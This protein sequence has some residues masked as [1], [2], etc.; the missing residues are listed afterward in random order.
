MLIDEL[1]TQFPDYLG[2]EYFRLYF[3][4]VLHKDGSNMVRGYS[5]P[6]DNFGIMF[7]N[8][9]PE[10]IAHECLHG[11]G[12]PHTFFYGSEEKYGKNTITYKAQTTKNIMDYSGM[13][14][15]PLEILNGKKSTYIPKEEYYLYYWQWKNVNRNIQ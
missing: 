3:M 4:D 10:T 13:K 9:D 12:L 15:N 8:H 2:S 5:N 6:N 1:T 14:N 11:L 7:K